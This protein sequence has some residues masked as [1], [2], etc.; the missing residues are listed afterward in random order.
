MFFIK[1]LQP[2]FSLQQL[3]LILFILIILLF[4]FLNNRR[5]EKDKNRNKKKEKEKIDKDTEKE[6]EKSYCENSLFERKWCLIK[7]ESKEIKNNFD[8][9]LYFDKIYKINGKEKCNTFFGNVDVMK[10]NEIKFSNIGKTKAACDI[11]TKL[12]ELLSKIDNYSLIDGFPWESKTLILRSGKDII[13]EFSENIEGIIKEEKELEGG[14][15]YLQVKDKYNL[16]PVNNN[17]LTEDIQKKSDLICNM[18]GVKHKKDAVGIHMFG[19]Y[20]DVINYQI[21]E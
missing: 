18:I 12:T 1:K 3:D 2:F 11:E 16:I 14:F 15:Y 10:K 13:L 4:S 9:S 17:E 8:Y 6:E 7:S 21:M 20:F 19:E 5:K